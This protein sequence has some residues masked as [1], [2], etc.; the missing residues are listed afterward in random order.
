M[1]MDKK[2]MI[3]EWWIESN[4]NGKKAVVYTHNLKV[5]EDDQ[6]L[7]AEYFYG[8]KIFAKQYRYNYDSE[9]FEKM[10]KK[11]ELN[12]DNR[13]KEKRGKKDKNND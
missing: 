12:E 10:K 9:E 6:F 2:E 13:I 3:N 1:L 8:D 5:K 7:M 4:P 11:L